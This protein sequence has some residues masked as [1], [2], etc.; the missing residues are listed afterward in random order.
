M[1]MSLQCPSNVL[2]GIPGV[3]D[4]NH[5]RNIYSRRIRS[6]SDGNKCHKDERRVFG[7]GKMPSGMLDMLLRSRRGVFSVMCTKNV[8]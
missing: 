8:S 1:M 4:P 6:D 3:E 7:T 2:V 5:E